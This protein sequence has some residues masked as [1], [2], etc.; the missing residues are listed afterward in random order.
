[1]FGDVPLQNAGLAISGDVHEEQFQKL[2]DVISR[3]QHNY[4]ELIDNLD[5][6]VFTISNNG[7]VRVANRRFCE[8]LGLTFTELIGH[9]LGDFVECPKLAELRNSL[10][11]FV[12]SGSWSGTVLVRLKNDSSLRYFDCWLQAVAE[13]GCITGVSGWARDV[14]AHYESEIRFNELFESLREGVFFGTLD[15]DILDANPAMMQ[16]LG[17]SS[18]E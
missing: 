16:L 17:Y 5:Q 7:E 10:Q 1:M 13:D 2:V 3:S 15:G 8:I 6:A 9:N 14:T 12:T 4:R 11:S 18:K